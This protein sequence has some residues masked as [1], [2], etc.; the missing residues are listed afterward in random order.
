MKDFLNEHGRMEID[1]GGGE[2][3]VVIRKVILHCKNG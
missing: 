2:M 1:F 3:Q